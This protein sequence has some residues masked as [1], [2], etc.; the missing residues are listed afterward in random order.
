[1]NHVTNILLKGNKKEELRSISNKN[2]KLKTKTDVLEIWWDYY[3]E[4]WRSHG[5]G[6]KNM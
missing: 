3:P 1:M 5:R 6:A 2:S 4:Q